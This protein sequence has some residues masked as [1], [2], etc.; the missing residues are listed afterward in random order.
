MALSYPCDI[1]FNGRQKQFLTSMLLS[2]VFKRKKGEG[3]R[4]GVYYGGCPSHMTSKLCRAT[5]VLETLSY[6][7]RTSQ[8]SNFPVLN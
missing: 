5:P 8:Q 1:L 4:I 7:H 2:E 3:L 6:G